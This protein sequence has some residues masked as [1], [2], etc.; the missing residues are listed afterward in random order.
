[1]KANNMMAGFS[2]KP[3]EIPSSPDNPEIKPPEE[4]PTKTWPEKNPEI[5]PEEEP[6]RTISPHE[7]PSPGED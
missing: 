1:M 2:K 6:E 3:Y 4:V 7:I 5:N